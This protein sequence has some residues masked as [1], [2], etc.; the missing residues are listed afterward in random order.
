L[1]GWA[2]QLLEIGLS[3]SYSGYHKHSA[4]IVAHADMPGFSR[5]DQELLAAII[6]GYRRKVSPALFKNLPDEHAWMAKCLCVLLRLSGRLHRGRRARA[7]PT[8]RLSVKKNRIELRF[9]RGWLSRHPLTRADLA[10]ERV[11]LQPLGFELVAR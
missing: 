10:D 1:I 11:R 5:E 2:S 7:V 9:P 8:L 6:Y 4:Y 3:I